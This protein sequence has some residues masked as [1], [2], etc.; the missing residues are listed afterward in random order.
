MNVVV[1]TT[2]VTSG[3]D[4]SSEHDGRNDHFMRRCK[5]C[6]FVGQKKGVVPANQ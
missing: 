5:K 6:G 2:I 3:S 4:G 1:V